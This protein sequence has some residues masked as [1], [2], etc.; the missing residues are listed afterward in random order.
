MFNLLSSET[1]SIFN[2]KT[3]TAML[4]ITLGAVL[5]MHSVYLKLMVFTLAGTAG[6][7]SSIGLPGALAYVVF[8]IEMVSGFALVLGFRQKFFAALV[9]PVLLGATWAHL[10]NGWLFSNQGGGWEYPLFLVMMALVVFSLA[11]A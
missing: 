5:L 7:F 11:D 4:R 2:P 8:L 3:G 1:F 6:Y 9:L 10:G